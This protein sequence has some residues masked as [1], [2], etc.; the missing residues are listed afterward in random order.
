MKLTMRFA[1]LLLALLVA[2]SALAALA[3]PVASEA[4][5]GGLARFCYLVYVYRAFSHGM[6]L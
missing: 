1:A 2:L 3:E 5:K 4:G 6:L